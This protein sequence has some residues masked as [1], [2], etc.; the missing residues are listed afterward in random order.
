MSRELFEVLSL[1]S[2]YL[3]AF[4]GVLISVRVFFWGTGL[5]ALSVGAGC[6]QQA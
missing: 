6:R 3:F 1:A 4:L 5:T 2:R